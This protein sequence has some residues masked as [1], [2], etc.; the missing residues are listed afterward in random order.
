MQSKPGCS[1]KISSWVPLESFLSPSVPFEFI[2]N[3]SWVPLKYLSSQAKKNKSYS[4]LASTDPGLDQKWNKID[5]RQLFVQYRIQREQYSLDK[6]SKNL[7]WVPL[8]YLSNP[9]KK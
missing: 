1:C 8:E 7:S 4:F 6:N 3:L 2:L 9:A 5:D